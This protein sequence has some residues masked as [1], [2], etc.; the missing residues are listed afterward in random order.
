MFVGGNIGKPLVSFL[1]ELTENDITVA[2]LS[3]FQ[4]MTLSRS[5][6]VAAITNITE[7]HLDYHVDMREYIAAKR[8]IF[9]GKSCDRLVIGEKSLSVFK[10][11]VFIKTEKS[12]PNEITEISDN[13]EIYLKNGGI[14]LCGNKVLNTDIIKIP[15]QHNVENYMTAIGITKNDA[16][17]ND[18]CEVAKAFPGAEHRMEFV[19]LLNGVSFYNSSIDSTPSRSLVTLKCFEKPLTVIAGGYDKRLD[20]KEFAKNLS[21]KA[22]NVVLTGDTARIIKNELDKLGYINN[23]RV[24]IEKDFEKAVVL[25]AEITKNSGKVLLSPASASFDAFANFEERGKRFKE[26]VN[27]L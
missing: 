20:Y 3:S 4:L 26:I 18:V 16:S 7:N 14:Y 9:S 19:R 12:F 11:N 13:G 5:P 15:G 24:Y 8:R 21:G 2:E 23:F 22:D 17:F 10:N 27:S 25:A 1:D 6:S